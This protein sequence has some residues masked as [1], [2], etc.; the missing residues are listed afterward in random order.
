MKLAKVLI[1][2][3]GQPTISD[4]ENRKRRARYEMKKLSKAVNP[5]TFFNL[6]FLR[7]K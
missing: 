7:G 3:T 4:V 1:L 6:E 5:E 2:H